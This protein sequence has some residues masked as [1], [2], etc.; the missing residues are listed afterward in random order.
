MYGNVEKSEFV[1]E[2]RVRMKD[3]GSILIDEWG[4]AARVWAFMLSSASIMAQRRPLP[5]KVA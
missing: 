3:D 5:A 1:A 4:D 2:I